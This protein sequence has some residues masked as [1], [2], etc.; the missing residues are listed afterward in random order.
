ML[1]R[2]CLVALA[3]SAPQVLSAQAAVS[4][5]PA[6]SKSPVADALRTMEQRY[7]RILVAA[8]EAMP[9]EK[10]NYRPTPGQMSFAQ[11]QV[12]LIN[13]GNDL[14]CGKVA[15]MAPPTRTVIDTTAS[16]DALVARL[17]ESFAFCEQ[18]FAKLD[19]SNLSQPIQLFGPVTLASAMMIT[20]GDW[21]DH[22]SQEANYL[23][24]N[25]VLPPT[26][27]PRTP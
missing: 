16:K 19:D 18:A 17:K 10:Y 8:A 23:R 12:H 9:A 26:A 4:N 5:A 27:R 2:T 6:S 24:L 25:G 3:I 11:V 15:G 7:A 22:Y 14:L 13:E 1:F 20:V 21:A